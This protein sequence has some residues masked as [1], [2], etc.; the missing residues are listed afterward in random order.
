VSHLQIAATLGAL[1]LLLIVLEL[2]R[3]RRLLERYALVWLAVGA[4]LVVLGAW[5]G[6]LT[7]VAEAVGIADPTNALF[8]V[9]LGFLLLIVLNLSVVVSRLTDQTKVLAQRAALLEQ[10]IRV[11]EEG[12]ASAGRVSEDGA[13]QAHEPAPPSAAG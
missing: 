9:G 3:R 8:A 13:S 7:T 11:R 1:A 12:K 6:L 10:Q 5:R 4:A 2:V